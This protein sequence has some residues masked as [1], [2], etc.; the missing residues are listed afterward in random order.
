ME[1]M[2]KMVDKIANSK[3]FWITFCVLFLLG[4]LYSFGERLYE[5]RHMTC[6][7]PT[8]IEQ[9]NIDSL[10]IGTWICL[11]GDKWNIAKDTKLGKVYLYVE[12]EGENLE[13]ELNGYEYSKLKKATNSLIKEDKINKERLE[14][15]MKELRQRDAIKIICE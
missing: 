9:M 4:G 10:V 6:L 15:L 14:K 12:F 5:K 1:K 8:I 13:M 11:N 3:W 2:E 7:V